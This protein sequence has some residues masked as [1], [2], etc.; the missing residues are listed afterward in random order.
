[1]GFREHIKETS[2][3][4]TSLDTIIEAKTMTGAEIARE[5]KIT[6]QAVSNTLKRAMAKVYDEVKKTDPEWGPFDRAVVM[7]QVFNVAQDSSEELKKFFKLFP[8]KIRKEI[9]ADAAKKYNV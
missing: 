7:S 9:E 8:P 5:L 3:I 1:M 4:D 6:T 2:I